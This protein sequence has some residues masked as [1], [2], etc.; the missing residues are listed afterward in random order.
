MWTQTRSQEEPHVEMKVEI[1]AMPKIP[2]NHQTPGE[3]HGIDDPLQLSEGANSANTL[4]P[5]F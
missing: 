3:R 2:A 5:D 1:R 4:I